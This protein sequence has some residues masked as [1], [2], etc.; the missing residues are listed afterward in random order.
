MIVSFLKHSILARLFGAV[1]F[2]VFLGWFVLPS[3]H[4][5]WDLIFGDHPDQ[6]EEA[7]SAIV[8]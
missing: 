3:C 2:A 7:E 5:Q 4:C 6:F 1:I 8:H